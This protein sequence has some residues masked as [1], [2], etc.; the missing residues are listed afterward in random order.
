MDEYGDVA[1]E[2]GDDVSRGRSNSFDSTVDS[3]ESVP[4]AKSPA[5]KSSRL[6]RREEDEAATSSRSNVVVMET[7]N[8]QRPVRTANKWLPPVEIKRSTVPNAGLG[9]FYS[10]RKTILPGQFVAFF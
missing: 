2:S 5:A 4:Y 3:E 8:R 7:R 10:G 6:T 9:L 1:S